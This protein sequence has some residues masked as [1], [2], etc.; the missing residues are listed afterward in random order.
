MVMTNFTHF[1][2]KT[3]CGYS[4]DL[5][6]ILI[7]THKIG[8]YGEMGKII[9]LSLIREPLHEETFFMQTPKMK[10]SLRIHLT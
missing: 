4:L 1:S 5:E 2:I 6:A 8:F 10:I 3:C 7:S 9:L